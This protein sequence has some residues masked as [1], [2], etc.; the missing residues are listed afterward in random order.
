MNISSSKLLPLFLKNVDSQKQKII[1][2]NMFLLKNMAS[3]KNITILSKKSDKSL[4]SIKKIIDEVE[5]FVPVL[6][7]IDKETELK[8]LNKEIKKIKS[9]ILICEEKTSNQ[10][11]LRFAPKNIINQQIENLKRLNK[12]Y[13]TLCKQLELFNN[14]NHEQKEDFLK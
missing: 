2:E 8:R 12:I 14:S 13:S 11:F 10:N 4:L 6:K 3:L 5:V 7:I 1:E 9:K